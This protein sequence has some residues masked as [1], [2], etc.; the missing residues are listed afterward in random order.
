MTTPQPEQITEQPQI[1]NLSQV[2]VESIQ[3]ELVRASL[4]AIGKL[5][6]EEV[7]MH[8]SAAGAVHAQSLHAHESALGAVAC[9]QSVVQ[10]S[11]AGA[12]RADSINFN[13]VAALAVANS[14]SIKDVNSIAMVGREITADNIRTGILIS[15]EVHGNVTTTLDGRTALLSALAGGAVTGLILLA[16]KLLF[17]HKK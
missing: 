7:E 5:N 4:T 12:I 10:D 13:G 17:G 1:V 11:I 8:D 6:A 9:E 16:G 3:A 14:I 2:D 15:R